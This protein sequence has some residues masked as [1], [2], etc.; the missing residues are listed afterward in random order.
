VDRRN[1]APAAVTAAIAATSTAAAAPAARTPTAGAR[2]GSAAALAGARQQRLALFFGTQRVKRL[3]DAAA[4]P[5]AAAA[6]R[7]AALSRREQRVHRF[8]RAHSAATDA[9]VVAA[10]F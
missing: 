6:G 1:G 5:S 10:S 8:G 7:G 9:A 2:V 4:T 3:R